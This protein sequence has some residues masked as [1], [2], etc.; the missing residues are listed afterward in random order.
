MLHAHQEHPKIRAKAN[1]HIIKITSKRS[2]YIDHPIHMQK[3]QIQ[4]RSPKN[5]PK[6]RKYLHRQLKIDPQEARTDSPNAHAHLL[7]PV[8][9]G[10]IE[11]YVFTCTHVSSMRTSQ[12]WFWMLSSREGLFAALIWRQEAFLLAT[13]CQPATMQIQA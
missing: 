10:Q 9:R 4:Y 1:I 6:R 2:K 8:S 5:T 11:V 13:F 3:N 7:G 12:D